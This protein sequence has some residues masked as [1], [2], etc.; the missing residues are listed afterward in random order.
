MRGLLEIQVEMITGEVGTRDINMGV[1]GI[2][3]IFK[4]MALDEITTETRMIE[5]RSNPRTVSRRTREKI[6]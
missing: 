2:W 5:K 4:F 6:P 1:T 3:M